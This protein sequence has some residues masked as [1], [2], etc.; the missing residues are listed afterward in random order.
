MAFG[1]SCVI[2]RNWVGSV[3]GFWLDVREQLGGEDLALS[4]D[5]LGLSLR[6]QARA[7]PAAGFLGLG[8]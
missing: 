3:V 1:A 2:C 7:K 8:M 4:F 5:G 6:V